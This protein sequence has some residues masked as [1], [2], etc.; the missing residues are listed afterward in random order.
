MDGASVLTSHLQT[1]GL[2]THVQTRRSPATWY[3][4]WETAT[5]NDAGGSS[6]ATWNSVMGITRAAEGLADTLRCVTSLKSPAHPLSPRAEF[7]QGSHSS[8]C[9]QPL[10]SRVHTQKSKRP[11][12]KTDNKLSAIH[13]GN[14]KIRRRNAGQSQQGSTE[15]GEDEQ[16]IEG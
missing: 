1:C 14:R 13:S 16:G 11:E 12:Q 3:G 5:S 6:R 15:S 7:L 4:T 2:D 9:E 8:R 10:Q